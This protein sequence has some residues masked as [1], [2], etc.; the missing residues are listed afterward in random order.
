MKK[1]LQTML[2]DSEIIELKRIIMD[3]DSQGALLFLQKHFKGKINE[4]LEGG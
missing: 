1:V 2:E 3:D 4:L